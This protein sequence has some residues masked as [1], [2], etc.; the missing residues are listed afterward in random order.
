MERVNRRKTARG[1]MFSALAVLAGASM[2]LASCQSA[3]FDSGAYSRVQVIDVQGDRFRNLSEDVPMSAVIQPEDLT[4][5][6]VIDIT[7]LREM[8]TEMDSVG[9]ARSSLLIQEERKEDIEL[10]VLNFLDQFNKED[11]RKIEG[12]SREARRALLQYDWPGNIRELK[13]SIES[14]VVLAKGNIIQLEDLP[15][16]ITGNL[17]NKSSVTIDLPTTLE[18]AEKKIILGTIAYCQGNK[19]KAS[20]VLDI[21]RKTLHRKLNEYE[22]KSDGS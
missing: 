7:T 21:G 9:K 18:Q 4:V 1:R 3:A 12:I 20:E 2:L 6:P 8:E 14:S 16:Q 17:S 5:S 11:G 13:N 10:L 22:G 15:A 19:S